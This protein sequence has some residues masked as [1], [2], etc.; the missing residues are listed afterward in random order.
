ME[1]IQEKRT[2]ESPK[3]QNWNLPHADN[4]LHS[5]CIVLGIINN[6]VSK[7]LWEDVREL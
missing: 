6:L 3:K 5:I 2:P 1:T 7:R 4:Y